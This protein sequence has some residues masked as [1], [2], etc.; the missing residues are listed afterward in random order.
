M[1]TSKTSNWDKKEKDRV[2]KFLGRS[3]ARDLPQFTLSKTSQEF[4]LQRGFKPV[5]TKITKVA[6]SSPAR[7][8]LAASRS[9][10]ISSVTIL[11]IRG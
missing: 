6:E 3:L 5:Y 7:S 4:Y 2:G 9:T 10:S 8:V 11:P 1:L